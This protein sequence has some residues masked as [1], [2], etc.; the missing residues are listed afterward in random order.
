MKTKLIAAFAFLFLGIGLERSF[1]QWG[2]EKAV[3]KTSAECAICEQ[4][5][6]KL[7]NSLKGVKKADLNLETRELTVVFKPKKVSLTDIKTIISNAGWDADEMKA[8]N[9]HNGKPKAPQN[10]HL[11]PEEK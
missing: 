2:K 9:K 6:E 10:P 3:I 1:A 8:K 11:N 7:V 4:Q 5:I